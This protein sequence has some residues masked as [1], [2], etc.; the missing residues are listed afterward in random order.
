MA[1]ILSYA[2][3]NP[4]HVFVVGNGEYETAL[5][6]E[7]QRFAFGMCRVSAYALEASLNTRERAHA[8]LEISEHVVKAAR[9]SEAS[10]EAPPVV[11]IGDESLSMCVVAIAQRLLDRGELVRPYN[12]YREED[13]NAAHLV[14]RAIARLRGLDEERNACDDDRYPDYNEGSRRNRDTGGESSFGRLRFE[15]ANS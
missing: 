11:V 6:S 15:V 2:V 4:Y 9:A 10:A 8:I 14:S 13:A 5:A 12:G 7:P 3:S 1:A